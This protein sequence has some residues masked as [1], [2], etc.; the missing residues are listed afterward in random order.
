[1]LVSR[2]QCRLIVASFPQNVCEAWGRGLRAG[3][4]KM[5]YGLV[6]LLYA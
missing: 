1:M 5:V 3:V 4:K 6:T 2:R